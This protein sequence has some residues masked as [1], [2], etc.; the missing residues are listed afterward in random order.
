MN[1]SLKQ[2]VKF[3]RLFKSKKEFEKLKTS[4]HANSGKTDYFT[5]SIKNGN[6]NL[7]TYFQQFM[8]DNNINYIG[9]Q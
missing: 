1:V 8:K 2:S 3:R 7:Y 6:E 9:Y 5:F 4:E